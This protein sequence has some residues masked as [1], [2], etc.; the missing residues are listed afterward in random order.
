[1]ANIPGMTTG[2]PS[3]DPPYPVRVGGHDGRI[4]TDNCG[5][6]FEV[7]GNKYIA[8]AALLELG[9][10]EGGRVINQDD[11]KWR[12]GAFNFIFKGHKIVDVAP[13]YDFVDPYFELS[14][15]KRPE[16]LEMIDLMKSIL[17]MKAFL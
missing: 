2:L 7:I 13:Y 10:Y 4:E 1:M 14:P 12:E 6:K 3:A 17:K 15:E 16:V 5:V 8:A 11:Y 9:M